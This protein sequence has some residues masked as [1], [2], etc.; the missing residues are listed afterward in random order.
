[1]RLRLGA[2]AADVEGATVRGIELA[3]DARGR[4]SA[5]TSTAEY[6]APREVPLPMQTALSRPTRAKA[7]KTGPR[8][9]PGF[10]MAEAAA[11][12]ADAAVPQG[13]ALNAKRER[14]V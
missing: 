3:L 1:M 11:R 14:A 2:V 9:L 13:V 7:D 12:L 10:L 4:R 8:R 6:F 5:V